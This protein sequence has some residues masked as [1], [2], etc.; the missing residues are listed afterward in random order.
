V[1]EISLH[2]G[3]ATTR[4]IRRYTDD[5]VSD[6]QLATIM[7]LATRAPSGSN[8]QPFRFM[9]L[10]DGERARQ[11]RALL[12]E[13]AAEVWTAKKARREF[14]DEAPTSRTARMLASMD[15]YVA[16]FADAPVIVLPC[17]VRYR[18]STPSEGASIYPAVQNLLLGARS[19]GLGGAL[20]M[21]HSTRDAA[22]R[23]AL[24]LPEQA[25]IAA[26]ITLGVP[27]G[28]PGP[29]RRKPIGQVVYEDRWDVSPDWAVDPEGTRFTGGPKSA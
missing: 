20:T 26:T 29:V 3:L 18:E 1:T 9:V 16:T 7:H 5:L 28:R 15:H 10:R 27:A 12:A 14:A 2:Q 19:V 23:T 13:G 25:F 21:F 4:T 24:E 11:V 6:E 22:I 17:M 8:R